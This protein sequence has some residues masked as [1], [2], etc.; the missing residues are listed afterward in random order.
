MVQVRTAM[1]QRAGSW[2]G[3]RGGRVQMGDGLMGRIRGGGLQ[4]RRKKTCEIVRMETLEKYRRGWGIIRDVE[5][6]VS[7]RGERLKRM[8]SG[9]RRIMTSGARED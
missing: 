8:R 1:R 9:L 2:I 3:V 5:I 7:D 4:A 6:S